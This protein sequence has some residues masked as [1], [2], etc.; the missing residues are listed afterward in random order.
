MSQKYLTGRL[1]RWGLKIEHRKEGRP[2]DLDSP[3]FST[4]V[5]SQP[6]DDIKARSGELPDLKVRINVIYKRLGFRIGNGVVDRETMW[7]I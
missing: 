4:T 1:A 5:Y 6:R 3:E 7:K 2:I